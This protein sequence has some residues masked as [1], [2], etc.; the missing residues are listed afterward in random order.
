M[1]FSVTVS[2]LGWDPGLC[3]WRK[4]SEWQKAAAFSFY[5][6]DFLILMGCTSKQEPEYVLSKVLPGDLIT[7]IGRETRT[8]SQA[9]IF[10]TQEVITVKGDTQQRRKM[11]KITETS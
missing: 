1:A 3:K 10:Q 11:E 9:L 2:F 4:D 8:G 5:L 6:L 7:V